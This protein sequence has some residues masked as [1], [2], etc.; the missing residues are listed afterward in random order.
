MFGGIYRQASLIVTQPIH[1]DLLD[2]GGPG[3][4]GRVSDIH[5]ATASVQVATRVTNSEA[6]PRRVRV[7]TVILGADNTVVASNTSKLS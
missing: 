4:Y 7:E 6:E 5:P 3:I 2:F 1:V